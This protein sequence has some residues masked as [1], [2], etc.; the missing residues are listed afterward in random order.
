MKT[1]FAGCQLTAKDFHI[2]QAMLT[3]LSG[4]GSPLVALLRE[5]N[6]TA[7]IVLPERIDPLFVTLNSRVEFEIDD[8]AAETRIVVKDQFQHGL[9]GLTLP[10]STVRG[11]ALLGRRQGQSVLFEEGGRTRRLFVRRVLYQPE[12][13]RFMRDRRCCHGAP[14]EI[15]DFAKVQRVRERSPKTEAGSPGSWTRGIIG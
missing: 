5:K 12:A 15:I 13:R 14:A 8:G 4:T 3:R 2:C 11:L 7:L 6:E 9:V 10:L 1:L